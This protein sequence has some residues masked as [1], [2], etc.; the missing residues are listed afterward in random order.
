MVIEASLKNCV[1]PDEAAD[2]GLLVASLLALVNNI[3][4]YM[5]QMA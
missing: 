1:D 3:S 5:Q 2:L 4:K